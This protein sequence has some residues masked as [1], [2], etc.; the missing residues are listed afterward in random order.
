MWTSHSY[1]SIILYKDKVSNEKGDGDRRHTSAWQIK[2]W[3]A[4]FE[5]VASIESILFLTPNYISQALCNNLFFLLNKLAGA[6]VAWKMERKEIPVLR[7]WVTETAKPD[8]MHR[9]SRPVIVTFR[10]WSRWTF[11]G[12]DTWCK[13][14]FRFY[15]I[16]NSG[17]SSSHT[18]RVAVL[19][20]KSLWT[21][22]P[23]PRDSRDFR[24]Y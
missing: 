19:I 16:L 13:Q 12:D 4:C 10:R 24:F 22:F 6:G 3:P 8:M 11:G 1:L 20:V 21:S 2:Y 5:L 23:H 17:R 9:P 18:V 15:Y 7:I 14:T